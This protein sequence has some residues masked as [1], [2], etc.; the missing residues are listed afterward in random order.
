VQGRVNLLDNLTDLATITVHMRP[1]AVSVDGGGGSGI[2]G[3]A[4][5][6]WEAS[7]DSLRGIATAVVVVAAYSWWL[8][9][10]LALLV[11][12]ARWIAR[13]PAALTTPT[14]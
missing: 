2:S 5:N 6:A 8:L 7:L 9:P 10:P 11:L 4:E 14:A 3:A 13:R 12:A 1:A